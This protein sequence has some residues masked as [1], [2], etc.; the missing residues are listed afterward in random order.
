MKRTQIQVP[1]QLFEEALAVAVAKEISMAELVRRGLEYMVA[2]TRLP[3]G[4]PEAWSLPPPRALNAKDP[5]QDQDWREKIHMDVLRV[6]EEG[7]PYPAKE[8]E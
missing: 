6:A 3:A 7:L 5:F 8:A 4:K 1:D 2:V